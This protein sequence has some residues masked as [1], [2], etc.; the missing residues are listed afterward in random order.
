MRSDSLH[1]KFVEF[2]P[3]DLEEGIVYISVEYATAAH[4]CA[5][6]CGSEVNTPLTPTGRDGLLPG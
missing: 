5:C 3:A 4:K 1:H 2:I 6:G